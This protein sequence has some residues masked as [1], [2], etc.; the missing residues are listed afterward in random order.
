[1][2]ESLRGRTNDWVAGVVWSMKDKSKDKSVS[3]S[4]WKANLGETYKMESIR[5]G[6]RKIQEK[7]EGEELTKEGVG[8]EVCSYWPS[9]T[10][11]TLSSKEPSAISVSRGALRVSYELSSLKASSP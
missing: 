11:V 6:K 10:V 1:M 7:D 8:R 2:F 3:T 5:Q 4:I 9:P